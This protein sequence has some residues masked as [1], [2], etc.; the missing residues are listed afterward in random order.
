MNALLIKEVEDNFSGE[1]GPP[2]K[3]VKAGDPR[4][5]TWT[6]ASFLSLV[7]R[8]VV[9]ACSGNFELYAGI[10]N[11]MKRVSSFVVFLFLLSCS[12]VPELKQNNNVE[13]YTLERDIRWASPGGFDLTMDIYTPTSGKPSYP[14]VVMFHGGGFLLNDK[15]IMDQSAAYLATN[16][17]Y[18][19]C[20]VN[21][22]LLSDRDNTTTL[23]NIVGDAF[24]AVLWVKDKI[25]KYKGDSARLA[26]TGDSAG[27]HL[28]AMI[29]NM[30]AELGSE[31]FS[32]NSLR[33]LPSYLPDGESA[34][35]VA[36]RNG[37][38]VQAAILSYPYDFYAGAVEGF[39]NVTNPL[40]LVKGA[41]GRGVFGD[42]F[43]LLEHHEMYKAV[44]PIDNIPLSSARQLPPQLLIVG[45]E[46]PLVSPASVKAY[47]GALQ[48]AGHSTRYWE[49][50]GKSH[51][52]LD[53]GSN[54]MLGSSFEVDA[55]PALDVMIEF[56][57][58]VF[59]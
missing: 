44:S 51:A 13:N 14:V 50:V 39:E 45:S 57:D 58:G 46:D 41:I 20:N 47:D 40:W 59:Y 36:M 2:A 53:S 31:G 54:M 21:Y 4:S 8:V 16:S 33:F 12:E 28:S 35:E 56:L 55:P 9:N 24:G 19:I 18:V 43:N 38:E 30:G 27:G 1:S 3:V 42:Q 26:V 10:T 32:L 29:V 23:N 49:Y 15:S 34:E 22:R 11:S 7:K 25:G 52:F 17:E 37:L 6:A 48:A 5:K